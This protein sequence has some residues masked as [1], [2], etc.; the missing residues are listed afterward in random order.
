MANAQAQLGEEAAAASI[1]GEALSVD[2][3]IAE[4]LG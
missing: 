2:V 4:V 3:V 1:A